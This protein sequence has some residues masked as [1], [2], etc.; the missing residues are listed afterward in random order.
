M[1][2]MLDHNEAD[3]IITLDGHIYNKDYVIAKEEL[4]PMHFVASA[5]SKFASKKTR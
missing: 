2:N 4:V 3:F 5:N 1:L